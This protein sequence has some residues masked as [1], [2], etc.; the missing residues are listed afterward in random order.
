MHDL[1]AVRWAPDA[2]WAAL[3]Q[4][5]AEQGVPAPS[6]LDRR[7]DYPAVWREPGLV[8]SQT[9]GYPYA[10]A[11]RG[12]VRLVATPCYAAPGCDGPAYCSLLLVRAQDPADE[13]ADLR[14][15]RAA[16]N[17]ADSQSGH[18]ALRAA[19]APLAQAGRFFSAAFPTGSHAASAAAVAA[20]EADLCAVDCVTWAMLLRHEPEGAAGLR[21]LGRTAPA[22]GLPLITGAAG[23]LATIRAALAAVMA[24][25]GLAAA[26]AALLLDGIE[27]L[28]D[29]AYDAIPVMERQAIAAGYPTLT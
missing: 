4:R 9:C 26:R 22:P 18:N 17:A 11:L 27:I 3:A 2:L 6:A 7:P 8:L 25:P 20:G 23:P 29:S 5:L 12:T 19:V 16:F 21:V 24:E 28:T 1:P 14:G 13:L 10:T 15:R